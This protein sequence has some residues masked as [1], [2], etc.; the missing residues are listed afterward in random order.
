[1]RLDR[2]LPP[3]RVHRIGWAWWLVLGAGIFAVGMATLP[4]FV[5]EPL[6]T[7]VHMG[8]SPLCHQIPS[9][10]PHVGGVPLA[11]CH[12]CYGIY[13]G[14]PLAALLWIGLKRREA[15]V[16]T[17]ARALIIASLVPL[18]LDWTLHVLGVWTNTPASRVATGL[19][20]GLM[21]GTLLARAATE[22]PRVRSAREDAPLSAETEAGAAALVA[23][24]STT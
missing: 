1:M 13:L 6:R 9:R 5:G 3:P 15:W 2:P 16:G 4:P 7:M 22:P 12:R 21:A 20:F 8:F 10:S 24:E 14:L 18:G 17:H 11:V 19:L 23:P